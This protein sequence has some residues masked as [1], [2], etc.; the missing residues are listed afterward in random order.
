[1]LVR[2]IK[3]RK[4]SHIGVLMFY[5]YMALVILFMIPCEL[6]ADSK[7]PGGEGS[8]SIKPF[9]SFMLPATNLN[10]EATTDFHAGKALAHQPWVKAPSS[11]TARDG[12]GPLY[13]ARTC[14]ACHING[15]RG[16]LPVD[17]K[18][19]LTQ[20]IVRLSIPGENRELG[21]VPE[22]NYG[23]QL[24]SQSVALSHQLG[25]SEYLKN[26]V[27]PEANV[28][29]EWREQVFV[30][31]EGNEVM[32]R[33]PELRF[34]NLGYGDF[35][36]ETL[37]SLRNAPALHGVGLLEQIPVT[38]LHQNVKS[39]RNSNH[40]SGRINMVWNPEKKALQT[41]ILGWKANKPNVKV[42]TAAAFQADV[43][44]TNE[45][46]SEQPC[47]AQQTKCLS[48]A[49]GM[50]E[51]GVELNNKLLDL[52]S[53]FTRNIGV[54]VARNQ[55]ST[56]IVSGKK[57][58]KDAQCTV[59]HRPSYTTQ[60]S[61]RFPAL[62]NQV[63]W[64]YTDL[65]LHDMGEELADNRPDF[66]A[67]GREWR[68]PPLWGIGLS[69]QVNGSSLLLHDGR[70]RTVEE[71]ILWHGGEAEQSKRFFIN[72]EPQERMNLIKFVESL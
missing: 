33:K 16:L 18:T 62:S 9:P 66:L 2:S 51:S 47:E 56:A 8:V 45:L 69:Q 42:Q 10:T 50:D 71:A 21:V 14:L 63:I 60:H 57:L 61:E 22:P 59:C 27:L 19:R 3:Y 11:T 65:L 5:L 31:H 13:N 37:M 1:M 55:S 72:L 30:Y 15:G 6:K 17:N 53:H 29:I 24:Q 67:T 70:A 52:V 48:Q 23:D 4:K 26:D 32:L 36:P 20:G 49:H 68:T 44:I 54:P 43:G 12:L 38:E 46:F 41:G 64:P 28:F 34:E 39:Q 40:I 7:F 35:H 58:F 25:L